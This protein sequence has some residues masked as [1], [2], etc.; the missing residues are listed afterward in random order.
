MSDNGTNIDKASFVAPKLEVFGRARD[1][2]RAVGNKGGSDGSK[3]GSSDK[4]A[5]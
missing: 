1:I 3:A 4:T 2:T 5:A